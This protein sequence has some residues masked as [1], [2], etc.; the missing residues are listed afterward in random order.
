[1]NTALIVIDFINDIAHSDG[2]IATAA[3]FINKN[4]TIQHANK[5]INIA[6][7]KQFLLLFIKVGF[8]TDYREC[9]ENSPVFGKVKDSQALKLGTWGTAFHEELAV[10]PHDIVITK[11]RVSAFYGT[12]LDVFLRT[13]QINTILLSGVA[14]NMTITSTAREAH[15]RDYNVLI[16]EEACAAATEEIH[17]NSL[18]LL[19]RVAN[20]IPLSQLETEMLY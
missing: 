6:R 10:L 2:K 18:E 20:V 15:D 4:K 17:R 11:H 14:T 9:P 12:S 13:N 3:P 8:S 5:L 1:M 7:E 19:S 16:I